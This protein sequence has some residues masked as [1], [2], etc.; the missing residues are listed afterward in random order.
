MTLAVNTLR[1]LAEG[2]AQRLATDCDPLLNIAW[3]PAGKYSTGQRGIYMGPKIP[4]SPD[5]VIILSPRQLSADPTQPDA[6][7][8]LQ[9]RYRGTTDPRTAWALASA[10]RDVLLGNFPTVLPGDFT[11]KTVTFAGG[12]ALAA[13]SAERA[14]WSD[15]YLFGVEEHRARPF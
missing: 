6:T 5:E 8:A 15:N 13:D 2:V 10:V 14:Q 1:A 7:Y 12:T 4:T 9:A 11:V 3:Q